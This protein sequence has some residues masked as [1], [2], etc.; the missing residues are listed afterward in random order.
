MVIKGEEYITASEVCSLLDI[1]RTHLESWLNKTDVGFPTPLV[2]GR[3]KY[4]RRADIDKFVDDKLRSCG[5][6][7]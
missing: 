4:W 3:M 5:I 6:I 1:K 7:D 2:I